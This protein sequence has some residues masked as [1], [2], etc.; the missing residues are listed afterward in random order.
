MKHIIYLLA[1]VTSLTGLRA[2]EAP[3]I[4]RLTAQRYEQK[5]SAVIA[6]FIRRDRVPD[7]AVVL[8]LRTLENDMLSLA[9]L[10]DEQR[11]ELPPLVLSEGLPLHDFRYLP[12]QLVVARLRAAGCDPLQDRLTGRTFTMATPPKKRGAAN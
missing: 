7:A 1:T 6:D 5:V 9:V 11:A 8:E 2:A 3:S 12:G 4:M 10:S